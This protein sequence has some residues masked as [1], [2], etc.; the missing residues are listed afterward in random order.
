LK[1]TRPP[2]LFLPIAAG[3]WN[4]EQL[5]VY[6]LGVSSSQSCVGVFERVGFFIFTAKMKNDGGNSTDYDYAI[7]QDLS[8]REDII[9]V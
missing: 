5:E 1:V 8:M 6:G 3:C 2:E 4:D 9:L 7:L